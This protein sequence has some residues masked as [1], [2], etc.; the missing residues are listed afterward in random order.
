MTAPS[1]QSI[2][3]DAIRELSQHAGYR[4]A[5]PLTS[6][7]AAEKVNTTA[8]E[9]GVVGCLKAHGPQTSTEIADILRLS[10]DSISPRMRPL[11]L[12]GLV[13]D[14]GARRSPYEG[15]RKQIVWRMK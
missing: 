13:E 14:S 7:R 4:H 11:A 5:D 12:R 3:E 10:R 1:P 15:T 6:V 8:L 2:F 9:A